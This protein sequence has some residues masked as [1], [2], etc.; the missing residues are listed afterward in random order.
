MLPKADVAAFPKDYFKPEQNREGFPEEMMQ[1]AW[2]SYKRYA[3]G[4]NELRPLTK[5]GYEG[6]MFDG[7]L[8]CHPGWSAVVRSWL[9]A[10]F[11]SWVQAILLP[12]PPEWNL[13]LLPR[14]ECSGSISAHCSL[15]LLGLSEAEV[16]RNK[17]LEQR[18][19][20]RKGRERKWREE[21]ETRKWK[22]VRGLPSHKQFSCVRL[23]SSWDY[24]ACHH[25]Q[26]IFFVFSVEAA[27]HHVSQDGLYLPVSAQS[28][29]I[30]AVSQL[31]HPDEA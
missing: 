16:A 15:L 10:T 22:E 5:D 25:A 3:M 23:L 2:Q 17:P 24:S 30:T 7:V 13:A 12:Q 11:A 9:T 27:F 21:V 14:L 1:F 31:C 8:L 19:E 26:L 20:E 28:A 4:K 29:R 18:T 6:N